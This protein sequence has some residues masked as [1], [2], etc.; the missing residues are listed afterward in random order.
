M[1]H[2]PAAPGAYSGDDGAQHVS[3]SPFLRDRLDAA[4]T[5]ARAE[6]I[7]V[8]EKRAGLLLSWAGIAY[9]AMVTLILTGPARFPGIGRFGVIVA[10]ILLSV[11]VL[12]IL[13]TIRPL[14]AERGGQRILSYADEPT[15]QALIARMNAETKD[16]ELFL[17]TD[18]LKFARVAR[19]KHRHLRWSVDLIVTGITIMTVTVFLERLL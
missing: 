6:L 19:A 12:L 4:T 9:G 5:A 8:S 1:N 10:L 14:S 16:Y 7:S 13:I 17:A 15:P 11:A 2:D 18:A 3:M